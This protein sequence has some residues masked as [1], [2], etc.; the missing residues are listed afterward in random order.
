MRTPLCLL[1]AVL[2]I[3]NLGSAAEHYNANQP[4][5]ILHMRLDVGFTT[6]GMQ[7]R[8]CEGRVE[9]TWRPRGEPLRLLH[10]DA[11]DMSILEVTVGGGSVKADFA[12]DDKV[13][14]IEL[15]KAVSLS[16]T[17]KVSIRYR[18]DDPAKGMHF[19][20]PNAS[21]PKRRAMV[22][23]MSEPLE[24]RYWMPTHD[25][26]N[27]R[28]TTDIIVTVPPG[29]T[30]VANGL[31]IEKTTAATNQAAVYH[32]R[33]EV[34]TDP[35]LMGFAIGELVE[36]TNSW[37]G[38]PIHVFTQPGLEAAARFTF[39]RVP[40]I[41]DFYSG[42]LG[43]EFPYPAYNHVTVVDHHHGGMEHAGFSFATPNVLSENE[44]GDWP[45]EHAESWLI[46]HMMAHQWFGGL[47][48]YRSVSQAWL[49]EGFGTYLDTL[50]TA[51]T[52]A[53][54]RVAWNLHRYA[55]NIAGADTSESGSPMVRRDLAHAGDIYSMDSSKIYYKGAWVVHMLRAQLG[56]DVFWQGV[57]R[58]L[59]DNT[60]ESVETQDLRKAFESVSGRDLEQFFQ[61]W[62]FGR[63]VPRLEVDYAWKLEQ[64]Q[65]VVTIRQTQ[66]IDTN[67]PAFAFP[68]ELL[69]R[70]HDG[71]YE[72]NTVQ[73][74]GQRHEF[75]FPFRAEPKMFCVDPRES[76]LKT[77]K[78][79]APQALL[80]EQARHAP[81]APA[82]W[83][84]IETL[85]QSS[86]PHAV[87]ALEFALN[88]GGAFW[89]VRDAAAR[90]LGKLQT[91]PAHAALVRA[92]ALEN[93]PR[94]LAAIL[95][96]LGN[97][98]VSSKAHEIV[99]GRAGSD[100]PLYVQH[101]AITAL[102]K[103]RGSA[104]LRDHSRRELLSAAQKTSRHYVRD[105]ALRA[106]WALDDPK[107][108]DP[109]LALAQ[110]GSDD[111]LRNRAVTLLGRLGR[112]HDDR[113]GT[114]TLLVGWL[115]DPDR[116]AQAAAAAGLGELKD[117]R[118][119]ADLERLR[120]SGQPQELG[121]A[122]QQAIDSIKRPDDPKYATS[123]LV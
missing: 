63:G 119:I 45:R 57:K 32:W 25:W 85:A 19:V 8:T 62:V 114:R 10:M 18:L 83:F 110:P 42:L 106:L 113:S 38:K 104:K 90:A 50:W 55:R 78:V 121:T 16:E 20:L 21:T 29:F 35:H 1:T 88:D 108:Y 80:A 73:V 23:T 3:A 118:A 24:A 28:W 12:Y 15:P 9:Y 91:E 46:S 61:Q 75:T 26:P 47:V 49:N 115:S 36:L 112:H 51:H 74:S 70:R 14:T 94:V 79:H 96:A 37:R 98:T 6:K 43:V 40:Q 102:G 109:V 111:R 60:G 72:T 116:D 67:T 68:L 39:E 117:P 81:T 11:V 34:P 71:A 103:L 69:F 93:P 4:A 27:E 65:A 77:L 95:E 13:L 86:T 2:L 107:T 5:D 120:A 87:A 64:R 56:E 54:E 53:P 66:K 100:Q 30:A 101:A 7:A 41:L 48:N 97:Y 82:R 22:Y 84:P 58:Y 76:L 59:E 33:S 52:D 92:S 105:A 123:A 31:L 99:L 122:A 17:G 89:G 44:N